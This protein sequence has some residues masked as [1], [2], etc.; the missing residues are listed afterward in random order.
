MIQ[1]IFMEIPRYIGIS[2]LVIGG[3][4]EIIGAL[5]VL[6]MPYFYLRA[7]AATMTV[8][9]GTVTPLLGISIISI[10]EMGLNGIYLVAI[11]IGVAVLILITAPTG[12]HVLVRAFF[13]T[14]PSEKRHS[15]KGVEEGS[16]KGEK[17]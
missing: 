15:V 10:T 16:E 17:T 5:G 13:T 11:C 1:E 2:L 9:G 8:V 12:S 3:I 7:H 4:F 6:K 14:Q